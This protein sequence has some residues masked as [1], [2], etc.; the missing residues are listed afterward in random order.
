MKCRWTLIPHSLSVVFLTHFPSSFPKGSQN[1]INHTSETS[2]SQDHCEPLDI[3]PSATSETAPQSDRCNLCLSH[4]FI[5][6][7]L[8]AFNYPESAPIRTKRKCIIVW[9]CL[10]VSIGVCLMWWWHAVLTS[11]VFNSELLR[12]V[13]LMLSI[14]EAKPLSS[15]LYVVTWNVWPRIWFLW[16]CV[17]TSWSLI[18]VYVLERISHHCIDLNKFHAKVQI[19]GNLDTKKKFW[20]TP[21]G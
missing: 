11:S 8:T 20:L 12:P 13:F 7:H 21:T 3:K 6:P 4:C 16:H 18:T 9:K 17:I 14:L 1:D 19:W 2:E 10:H 15:V 5:W